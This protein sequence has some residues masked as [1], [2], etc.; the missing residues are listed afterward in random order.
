VLIVRLTQPNTL[1]SPYQL[2]DGHVCSNAVWNTADT[3]PA[4]TNTQQSLQMPSGCG[5]AFYID[6]TISNRCQSQL[7]SRIAAGEFHQP[8]RLLHCDVQGQCAAV[9][10][11]RELQ[12]GPIGCTTYVG[13]TTVNPV[14]SATQGN[15]WTTY[16]YP[17]SAIETSPQGQSLILWFQLFGNVSAAGCRRDRRV[18]AAGNTTVFRDAVVYELQKIHPGSIRYMDPSQWCAD[19]ADEITS[20]GTGAGAE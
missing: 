12:S 8:E 9:W 14:Y 16:T 5:L 15:G 10:M 1:I 4:S 11:Q 19:V 3:S 18:Y 13:S 2:L 6:A 20:T 17:F 7:K